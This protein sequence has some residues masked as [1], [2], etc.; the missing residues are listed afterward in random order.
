MAGKSANS[1]MA[2]TISAATVWGE[3]M[4]SASVFFE[5]LTELGVLSDY[6]LIVNKGDCF[7]F[8]S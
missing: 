2:R 4:K 6:S 1:E 7:N 3:V 8:F 5:Y